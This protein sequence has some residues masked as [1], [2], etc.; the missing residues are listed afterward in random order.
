MQQEKKGNPFDNLLTETEIGG[1]KY[2][3]YDLSKL[4]DERINKLPISIRVLLECA[5]RN[6]DGFNIK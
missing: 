3:F 2:R 4:N 1:K 6:C 5:I